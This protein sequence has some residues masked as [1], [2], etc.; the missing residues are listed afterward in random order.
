MRD[1]HL[2]GLG[3]LDTYDNEIVNVYAFEPNKKHIK[4]LNDTFMSD[5]TDEEI[6]NE[7]ESE[8]DEIGE[9][10]LEM[11]DSTTQYIIPRTK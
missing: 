7:S 4:Q 1:L 8:T 10:L 3:S 9:D 6:D 2:R 11:P 5:A